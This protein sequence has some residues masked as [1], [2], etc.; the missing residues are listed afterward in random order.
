MRRFFERSWWRPVLLVMLGCAV[1][2]SGALARTGPDAA[3]TI[4]Y[5]VGTGSST[6]TVWIANLNGTG[7]RELGPAS[8]ALISPDGS[9]VAAITRSGSSW[10]LVLYSVTAAVPPVP[11]KASLQFM[12]LP[13]L[14]WSGD[15]RQL[16]VK[17]GASSPA[18]LW[19]FNVLTKKATRVATGVFDGASFQPNGTDQIVYADA[20]HSQA[21]LYVTTS[22]AT[23]APRLLTRNGEWPVWGQSG[24]VYSRTVTHK[25]TA[26]LQLWTIRPGGK[27]PHALTT[28]GYGTGQQGLA[29]IAVSS[30]GH[31]L[32]N[33]IGTTQDRAEAFVFDLTQ[34]KRN[35]RD[36]TGQ[37]LGTDSTIADAISVHGDLVLLTKG[38]APATQSIETES[39]TGGK[40]TVVVAHGAYASWDY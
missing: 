12:E 5:I 34:P 1:L 11:L 21:S 28:T 6:P 30:N 9:E 19:V 16:L 10:K 39:W 15:A 38:T 23:G 14:A 33:L 32:A 27:N 8:S 3:P 17:V 40:P 36:L 35:P 7:A 20:T 13:P 31:L 18:Q 37:G 2:A 29:P 22:T 25:G 26:A 4:T 24:I